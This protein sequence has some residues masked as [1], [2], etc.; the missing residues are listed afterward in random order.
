MLSNSEC[1]SVI[2][3][4]HKHT[5]TL[6]SHHAPH[7]TLESSPP[8]VL[9]ITCAAPGLYRKKKVAEISYMH[10]L[11]GKIISHWGDQLWTLFSFVR[12][13]DFARIKTSKYTHIFKSPI[14]PMNTSR[15]QETHQ[16]LYFDINAVFSSCAVQINSNNG[17][18]DTVTTQGI[19]TMT[20]KLSKH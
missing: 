2:N 15:R 4:L 16:L 13:V 6:M 1:N 5:L 11:T 18:C 7:A 14:S 3:T 12:L 20:S 8:T 19:E 10:I 17:D 9:W